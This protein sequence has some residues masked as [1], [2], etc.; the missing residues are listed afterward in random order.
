MRDLRSAADP[1]LLDSGVGRNRGR[2]RAGDEIK[3]VRADFSKECA[4]VKFKVFRSLLI[5]LCR[6]MLAG[7]QLV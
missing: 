4:E 7:E 5:L 6:V 3:V 1:Q 2:D